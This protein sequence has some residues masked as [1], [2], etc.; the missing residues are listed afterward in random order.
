M[1]NKPVQT[2]LAG[3][4][5]A[6]AIALSACTTINPY[7]GEQQTAKATT[8]ALIGAAAGAILGAA[9][10]DEGERRE[11]VLKGAGI[12]AIAGAGVGYYMDQQEAKLRERMAGTGVT[13]SRNGDNI[14]LNMPSNV[15]FDVNSS[16]LTPNFTNVLEGVALVMQEYK[17]TLVTI[18]GHTDSTGAESYNQELSR[19][20]ALTVAENL[21]TQGVAIERLAAIGYG[22]Q[23]PIADNNTAQGR[24]QNRRVEI[25]ID[26]IAQ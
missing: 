7:T 15:T 20:R 21:N 13:V 17:S 14:I 18:A 8:G 3:S 10:A 22:E 5:T 23:Y 25:S 19:K 4:L 12:G 16:T 11:R 6:L 1:Q 2:L 9:T 26:P 24:A